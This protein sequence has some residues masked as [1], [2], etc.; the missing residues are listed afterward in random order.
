M[1]RPIQDSDYQQL[2]DLYK[3]F[4]QTHNIFSQDQAIIENYLRK[5]S[6]EREDFLI[7]EEGGDIKGAIIIVL[8]GKS[9]DNTHSRWKFRHFAFETEAI[10]LDLLEYAEE[11]IKQT[12][13][14][15]KI[16]L[17]IAENEE[18]IEFYKN[19]GYEQE[20]MLRN[21]YRWD[22]T[23]FILGKSLQNGV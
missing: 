21:H 3:A 23:C 6:L 2:A 11:I 18:G 9:S 4:F 22:E 19:N 1:I 17:T 16:E 14:T 8:L 20:A 12:S 13:Q 10:A 5:E 7:F 15:C